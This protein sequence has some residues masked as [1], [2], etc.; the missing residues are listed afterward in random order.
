MSFLFKPPRDSNQG[1]LLSDAWRRLAR[2]IRARGKHEQ[3][4]LFDE[5]SYGADGRLRRSPDKLA[6]LIQLVE[7]HYVFTPDVYPELPNDEGQTLRF[8]LKH[9]ALHF[10]K[11]AG[12]LATVCEALDHGAD[13]DDATLRELTPKALIN[14]LKLAELI[15]LTEQELLEAACNRYSNRIEA[16]ASA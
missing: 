1:N 12:Q 6:D 2:S 8:A 15:G 3:Y 5:G 13:V 14:T 7:E 16:V 9:S 4:D 10:A 11:T